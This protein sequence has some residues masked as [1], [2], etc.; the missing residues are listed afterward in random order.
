MDI[1]RGLQNADTRTPK[2]GYA[3]STADNGMALIETTNEEIVNVA[4]RKAEKE[5]KW[6]PSLFK[7][8]IHYENN[9]KYWT[10]R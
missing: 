9:R 1:L 6:K 4:M 2:R 10:P 8:W 5:S 7:A 3:I